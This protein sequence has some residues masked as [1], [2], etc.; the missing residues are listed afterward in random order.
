MS[1]EDDVKKTWEKMIS[2]REFL[3]AIGLTGAAVAGASILDACAPAA[4]PTVPPAAAAPT[5]AAATSVPKPFKGT[6][7]RILLEDAQPHQYI[8]E[9]LNE[10]TDLTGIEVTADL[11]AWPNLL[12]QSQV[13]LSS[14]S[15]TYDVMT[16]VYINAIRWM[17][18]GWVS[19]L[20]DYVSKS[21]FD[22]SDF[23]S[24]T[25]GAMTYQGKL[26]G[27]PYTAESTQM[28]YRADLLAAKNLAVPQTFDDLDK[29]LAAIHNP[30]QFYA[31]VM[32]TQDTG[33]HFP[34]P[35]WL[36]GYGGNIFRDPP[37]DVTPTLNTPEA[38][39]ATTDFT[40]KIMKYSIAGGQVYDTP[41]CQAAIEQGKAGI[42]IDALGLTP[43]LFD[44]KTSTVADKLQ[45]ALVPGGP[46]GQ[47]PQIASHGYMIPVA[48]KNKDAS[49]ELIKWM[50]SKNITIQYTIST[51]FS[52]IARS[53]VLS[54]AAYGQ[55]YNKGESKIG[56]LIVAAIN[57]SKC[58]Y[59][60]IPEFPEVGKRVGDAIDQI[61]SGQMSVKDAMDSAQKDAVQIMIQAGEKI[62][63]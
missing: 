7:L 54:S 19:P 8:K 60:Q 17:R 4:T 16:M 49:W 37:N 23:L 22:T 12:T 25:T 45:I 53:S 18:A 40:S 58:A 15:G 56:D 52:A 57:K 2:R 14:A 63:P 32:R 35:I 9:H 62:T 30:P 3:R 59:R 50:A 51:N 10:F 21:G 34:F 55:K 41:D 29:V 61:I 38:I 43:P 31:Y 39:Q 33:V 46:A 42:W 36:Q 26:Y 5:T 24:Q 44:P 27:I 20:D 1:K 11:V 28:T 48:A 6:K 13:E 47:F